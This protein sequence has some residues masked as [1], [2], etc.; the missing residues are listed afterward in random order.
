M[1]K[2]WGLQICP[3]YSLGNKPP[4][5]VPRDLNIGETREPGGLIQG[6]IYNPDGGTTKSYSKSF[7][8]SSEVFYHLWDI[9]RNPTIKIKWQTSHAPKVPWSF[10]NGRLEATC[11]LGLG[12]FPKFPSWNFEDVPPNQTKPILTSMSQFDMSNWIATDSSWHLFGK[13]KSSL[14]IGIVLDNRQVK[15]RLG[16]LQKRHKYIYISPRMCVIF[17]NSCPSQE[18]LRP[19]YYFGHFLHSLPLYIYIYVCTKYI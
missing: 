12:Q 2:V 7:G 6:Q 14:S 10:K 4:Q 18:V 8:I 5:L 11:L 17:V 13:M 1:V 19:F 15:T 9:L 16:G 3:P